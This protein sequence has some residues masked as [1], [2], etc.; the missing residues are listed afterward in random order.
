MSNQ[1][2]SDKSESRLVSATVDHQQE[3]E[4]IQEPMAFKRRLRSY[5][6]HGLARQFTLLCVIALKIACVIGRKQR[7]IPS[8]GCEILLT[9]RFD[10]K[11]WIVNHLGPL[12]ASKQ[13][14]RLWMVST[15]PVPDLPKVEAIYPPRWLITITG[16]TPAR[17]LT[18]LYAAL[19]KRPHIVGGF[20]LT[21]N[22]MA[23]VIVGRLARARSMYFCVGGPPE[24]LDGGVHADDHAFAA[25][26]TPDAVVERRLL[27]IVSQSDIVITM[28]TRAVTFF[29]DKGLTAK[30]HVVSGGVDPVRFQPSK[31]AASL[32]LIWTGRLA[33]I[34]RLDVFL[35]AVQEVV[36]N[37]PNLSA[38]VVG[39]GPLRDELCSLAADLGIRRNVQFVGRKDNVEDWLRSA[40]I[41]VMTSDSEGLSLS[42]ME[43]MMCGLPAVVSDVGD[44]GDLVEDGVNGYLVPRRSPESFA[45][46]IIELLTDECKL[47]AFS[48][49][50]H[51]AAMQYETRATIER[52]D[53][54]LG[55]LS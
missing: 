9:G 25:M 51:Q 39:D 13:C 37:L 16:A 46:R 22:G 2:A 3:D 5:F 4:F 20:H 41:F 18:F 50:A 24:V 40:R 14:S 49:A 35:R 17:L 31:N 32:D 15:N 45:A 43:A 11:N 52:W 1:A 36:A 44:L 54:I 53:R 12:A 10:S 29:H 7:P 42:M 6:W 30:M 28:G 33:H 19:R 34:K 27:K 47:L 21:I 23:A 8:G 55:G 38:V 48:Q 26:E